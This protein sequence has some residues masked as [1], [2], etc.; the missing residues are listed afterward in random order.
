MALIV[1]N[2][3]FENE[4][5]NLQKNI[6]A[7]LPEKMR[8][9]KGN[10]ISNKSSNKDFK[11]A[12]RVYNCITLM[13]EAIPKIAQK[14]EDFTKLINTELF[15]LKTITTLI[16]LRSLISNLQKTLTPDGTSIM[17]HGHLSLQSALECTASIEKILKAAC[18]SENKYKKNN[19]HID[20]FIANNK[21]GIQ[22]F[23][24]ST[25]QKLL[26]SEQNQEIL[27]AYN[28]HIKNDVIEFR[29]IQ[30][31]FFQETTKAFD[32]FGHISKEKIDPNKTE[33]LI[34]LM[35]TIK[36]LYAYIKSLAFNAEQTRE[37]PA[38]SRKFFIKNP[39]TGHILITS[40]N[41]EL[42]FREQFKI[43]EHASKF[44]IKKFELRISF[45]DYYKKLIKASSADKIKQI[46]LLES[47]NFKLNFEETDEQLGK[48]LK[49]F[50]DYKNFL[51]NKI[52][53][54]SSIKQQIIAC[55][56]AQK[57]SSS[58]EEIT[59]L[60]KKI[61]DRLN[62]LNTENG[63]LTKPLQDQLNQIKDE[64]NSS[65]DANTLLR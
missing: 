17:C 39:I 58:I 59:N 44:L 45:Q 22:E 23:I 27:E 5:K 13:L 53:Y 49:L 40:F 57:T 30:E 14:Y 48:N 21:T 11:Q 20:F 56:E 19:K 34:K 37:N 4:L 33:E 62:P 16:T 64:I 35:L 42:D 10:L 6:W 25:K 32:F 26:I 2:T 50:E 63:T 41:K 28:K 65:S 31:N 24:Q 36:G 46:T 1:Q 51:W 52:K 12:Q 3:S 43:I 7:V 47:K 55:H 15:T 29:K 61:E 60:I 9:K 38:Y 54:L 8:P 18:S